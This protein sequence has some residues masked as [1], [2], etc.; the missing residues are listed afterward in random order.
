MR[1]RVCRAVIAD[2]VPAFV[3]VVL[4]AYR[5]TTTAD[6]GAVTMLG[7][8][9]TRGGSTSAVSLSS[10]A[11]DA[12]SVADDNASV[13][14]RSS[15]RFVANWAATDAAISRALYALGQL[16]CISSLRVQHTIVPQLLG[17]AV[18]VLPHACAGGPWEGTL[19]TPAWLAQAPT[20]GPERGVFLLRGVPGSRERATSVAILETLGRVATIKA[21]ACDTAAVDAF[22]QHSPES[23]EVFSGLLRTPLGPPGS[24]AGSPAA[25]QIPVLGRSTSWLADGDDREFSPFSPLSPPS[26]TPL[27][28]RDLELPLLLV[29]TLVYL[30]LDS[31]RKVGDS[32]AAD[33]HQ[34][35]HDP[36]HGLLS[37]VLPR[38]WRGDA[39]PLRVGRAA[40][41]VVRVVSIRASPAVQDGLRA[42]IARV[43][44]CAPTPAAESIAG[45]RLHSAAR[46]V[47]S[48]EFERLAVGAAPTPPAERTADLAPASASLLTAADL[49]SAV[50]RL[51]EGGHVLLA[52]APW[53]APCDK[54]AAAVTSALGGRLDL[55]LE[56]LIALLPV[57]FV[58]LTC[59]RHGAHVPD[60]AAV[61]RGLGNLCLAIPAGDVAACEDPLGRRGRID[62]ALGDLVVSP[63]PASHGG[64]TSGPTPRPFDG[65]RSAPAD[66]APKASAQLRQAALDRAVVLCAQA[67]GSVFNRLPRAGGD[68]VDILLPAFLAFIQQ[69]TGIRCELAA[70]AVDTPRLPP[71]PLLVAETSSDVDNTLPE[72]ASPS[73]HRIRAP[74]DTPA[75]SHLVPPAPAPGDAFAIS[76]QRARQ[77][78]VLL[79]VWVCKGLAQR[80][81][82]L[83]DHCLRALV[84]VVSGGGVM[85]DDVFPVAPS[86]VSLAGRGL[87]TVV[88]DAAPRHPLSREAGAI[89][90]GLYKQ[91]IFSAVF[92]A[93]QRLHV[94]LATSTLGSSPFGSGSQG[95]VSPR[96]TVAA[97]EASTSDALLLENL[98]RSTARAVAAA[99][100][101]GNGSG[102]G[103]RM[104]RTTADERQPLTPNEAGRTH[105]AVPLLL[106]LCAI[107]THLPEAAMLSDIDNVLPVVLRALEHATFREPRGASI[108]SEGSGSGTPSSDATDMAHSAQLF[109]PLHDAVV[110]SALTCLRTLIGRACTIVAAHLNALVP[111]LL[112]L[113]QYR[114]GLDNRPLVRATAVDCLRGFTSLPY[115][116]LHAVKQAVL[117]GLAPVLDDPKRSVRRRAAA[118]RNEWATLA[119]SSK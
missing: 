118:C 32:S 31:T 37:G 75:L 115:H 88:S 96:E 3:A 83:V 58:S 2:S 110:S 76:L 114:S 46:L 33:A 53:F 70:R 52:P 10:A 21:A 67:V 1:A 29:P 116:S 43:I 91:K 42:A 57:F 102:G 99:G 62:A 18:S 7:L 16:C 60:A 15:E 9:G 113:A 36:P 100:D 6:N 84:G 85:W 82:P 66:G 108:H 74:R 28:D 89:V 50:A 23:L 51:S 14:S 81:H 13:M 54:A 97:A 19:P 87:G 107:A 86:L 35:A 112:T 56:P 55:S 64:A 77:R 5:D 119:G 39:L 49:A 72:N 109:K 104:P 45:A 48:A 24:I 101:D 63:A 22:V 47:L 30:L 94:A 68:T 78:G 34:P 11:S 103:A 25:A 69:T 4:E 73:L 92:A 98:A 12:G 27:S 26:T 41:L 79:L 8:G 61:L 93:Y 80:G 65:L 117:E 90:A 40:E 44:L 105:R 38:G 17:L 71:S 106:S 111:I 20:E 59:S 95:S